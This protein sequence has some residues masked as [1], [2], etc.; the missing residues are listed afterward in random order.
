MALDSDT[1]A[2]SVGLIAGTGVYVLDVPAG[3]PARTT[4]IR[5][6]DVVLRIDA[7]PVT[8]P[9]ELMARW[10]TAPAGVEV[11]FT[12]WRSQAALELRVRR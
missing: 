8:E 9:A 12:L 11:A 10:S 6:G 2:S 7:D 4:G 3:S 1:L 5:T